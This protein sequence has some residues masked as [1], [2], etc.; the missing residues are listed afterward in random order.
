[1]R[2]TG[3]GGMKQSWDLVLLFCVVSG[4]SALGDGMVFPEVV[5]P[6]VEIPNQQALIHFSG[7]VERLVIETS[8]SGEGTN[9]AWVVPLPAVP[10]VRPVSEDF[11]SRL[12][13]A[14]A[15]QLVHRVHPYYAGVVFVCGLAF[16]GWRALRDEVSGLNDLALCVLLA[17]G[18]GLVGRH[19]AFGLVALAVAVCT[20]SFARSPATFALLLVIG[21][22][23]SACLTFIPGWQGFHLVETLGA[24]Q[25]GDQPAMISGVEVVSVQRAGVFDATTI[26]GTNEAGIVSWLT[27]NGYGTTEAAGPAI[28]RYV[29][30]GWVFVASKV[31]RGPGGPQLAALHP[32]A[33]VFPAETPVYP[34]ALTAINGRDCAIDLYVFGS[35]R[36]SA[37]H[38][39]AARCDHIVRQPPAEQQAGTSALRISDPEI[40]DLVGNSITGTK[41]SAKLTPRQMASDT[42]VKTRWFLK[43]G[44]TVYSYSGARTISANIALPLAAAGWL[45]FGAMRGGWNVKE[46]WVWRWRWRLLAATLALGLGVYLLLP[47]V[48]VVTQARMFE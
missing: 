2:I 7:G 1:M 26:R 21:C 14:F 41:L 13:G 44:S 25:A 47:K 29:E 3:V 12:R 16:L 17:G 15:P 19:F 23:F 48:E 6:K 27:R 31:R 20:R 4:A 46:H 28:R 33:F 11:F 22:A 43:T 24:E 35:R 36:A 37:P 18:A 5:Y 38:F 45:L 32:L 39:H 8:F 30:K 34:T 42:E 9:F 10:E 40:L